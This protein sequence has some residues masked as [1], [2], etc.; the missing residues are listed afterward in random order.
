MPAFG[1]QQLLDLY[2]C[3]A[4]ACDDLTLCYEFL[5]AVVRRLKMEQQ[6]PP[7][8]FRSDGD[9]Y[10]DK[11]GLSGWIPLI[12][13][14]IQIHTLTPKNFISIDI[15]SCRKFNPDDVRPLIQEFFLP[16]RMDEQFLERGVDYYTTGRAI[17]PARQR[18]TGHASDATSSASVTAD[19]SG[20]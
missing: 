9:K 6:S 14:G 10:P 13:S 17:P 8:I 11:A 19:A 7:F 4:G 3:K 20:R 5:V 15:Y 16:Q 12:E 18:R 2:D 1:Y